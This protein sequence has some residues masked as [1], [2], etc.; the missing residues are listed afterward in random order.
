VEFVIYCTGKLHEAASKK[1]SALLEGESYVKNRYLFFDI[2]GTLAAGGYEYTYVPESA[3]R[4]LKKLREAGHVLCIATGRS[5]GMAVEYMDVFGMQNMVSDGGYGITV[6]GKL[7]GVEPLPKDLVVALIDEC[8]EKGYPW[9]LVVDDTPRRFCP[10][11][12]FV[13]FTGDEYMESVIVPGTRPEDYDGVFKVNIACCPPDEQ[14]LET[15]KKL[16]WARFHDDYLFVEPTD[17]ARGIRRMM[18]HFGAPYEDVIVF[19]D[20]MND[21]SMFVPEWTCVAMGNACEELKAKA[22]YVTTDVEDDGIW[23]ACVALGLFEN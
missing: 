2:D 10:D 1:G 3:M 20:A 22:D 6:D 23:N 9:G 17:K 8:D 15:L 16:P 18:D 12:K 7:L 21:L 14:K 4:A 13:D 11:T 19:G 5:H